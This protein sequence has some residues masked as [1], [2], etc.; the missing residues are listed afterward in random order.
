MGHDLGRAI[1]NA[2]T[3]EREHELVD[4]LRALDTY[5]SQ[6]IATVSH[7]LK[8]PLTS[9]IGHLEMVESARSSPE[10][11]RPRSPPWTA[12]PPPEPGHRRPV[13]AVAGRRPDKPGRGRTRRPHPDRRRRD[14]AQRRLGEPQGAGHPRR[15]ARRTGA[16]AG[17]PRRARPA[18]RQPGEQRDQVHPGRPLHHAP[19]SRHGD[20]LLRPAP[21]RA[22]GSPSPTRTHLFNEFFRST[23]PE[24][25]AQ[26][27]TGLGLAIVQRIVRRHGG[28]IAVE[29][30]LG[31]GTTFV[32]TLPAVP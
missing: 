10:E 19:L 7:E 17:R 31:E 8:N 11:T 26:P 16:G 1:L 27:G 18:L 24:A 25:V 15:G 28:T 9:I 14:R 20:R 29:S 32:V 5:K 2:R 30:E 4:E 21:T 13:A 3:F 23:N 22:S 12:A 6:L